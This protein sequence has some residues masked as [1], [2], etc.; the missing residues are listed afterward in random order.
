MDEFDIK[1]GAE[2]DKLLQELPVKLERNILRGALRAGAVPIR[3][4]A[5]AGVPVKSGALRDSI[6]ISTGARGGK[7]TARIIAGNLKAFYAHLVEFGTAP[8]EE[9][10]QNGRSLFFAGLARTVV[11]H[12]GASPKPF[13]TPALDTRAAEA[14]N[15]SAEYL[16]AR[17]DKLTGK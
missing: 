8:H 3:D 10:P 2:L 1:G 6:R 14:V 5:K 17:L 13:M 15:T 16:R 7:V 9:R 12:P 4:A 11:H